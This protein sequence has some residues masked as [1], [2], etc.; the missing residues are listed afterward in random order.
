MEFMMTYGWAIILIV[1]AVS[2]LAYNNV[3][4]PS[5]YYPAECELLPNVNC[6]TWKISSATIDIVVRNEFRQT[7]N[8]FNITVH[9]DTD[10]NNG[11]GQATN[12]LNN[13]EEEKISITCPDTISDT[14][15]QAQLNISY[16]GT[17]GTRHDTVGKISGQR[18]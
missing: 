4:S 2:I 16:T 11:F 15:Y 9:S 12:G 7:L 17:A 3:F 1:I 10:C 5:K 14:T 6:K 18:E 8:P 13:G